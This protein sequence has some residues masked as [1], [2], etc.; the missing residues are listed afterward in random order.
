MA[1]SAQEPAYTKRSR[2]EQVALTNIKPENGDT[3]GSIELDAIWAIPVNTEAVMRGSIYNRW[4]FFLACTGMRGN[5]QKEQDYAALE[6]LTRTIVA[7]IKDPRPL[8]YPYIK[9]TTLGEITERGT[10]G[11]MGWPP[12][13]A[14]PS[15][16]VNPPKTD[17][18]DTPG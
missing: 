11:D 9:H 10:T 1:N 2:F 15:D 12:T 14:L 17:Y 6:L 7:E 18:E 4:K 16:V 13:D 5:P 8:G 3:Y